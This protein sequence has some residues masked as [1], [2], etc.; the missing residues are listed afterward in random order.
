VYVE[1]SARIGFI[2]AYKI[3]NIVRSRGR[4]IYTIDVNPKPP[5]E[6]TI[7]DYVDVKQVKKLWFDEAELIGLEDALL[8]AKHSL[9]L[10]LNKINQML[11]KYFPSGTETG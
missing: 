4:W 5:A 6:A 10:K 9:E 2:E 11:Q 1:A 8:L 7:M 3:T